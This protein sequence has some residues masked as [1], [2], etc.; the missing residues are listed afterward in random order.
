MGKG[1]QRERERK[2]ARSKST[3]FINPKVIHYQWRYF[4]HAN[5]FS[6]SAVH[7]RPICT[8]SW[9]RTFFDFE[10]S[11][12][13][14][15]FSFL[16]SN[17]LSLSLSLWLRTCWSACD[18]SAITSGKV[19]HSSGSDQTLCRPLSRRFECIPVR[20]SIEPRRVCIDL[21][22]WRLRRKSNFRRKLNSKE[23]LKKLLRKFKE[24]QTLNFKFKVPL[25][26]QTSS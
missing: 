5:H 17:S 26:Y 4:R 18:Q 12:T 10:L 20:S 7:Q 13:S 16:T 6:I 8:H 25:K 9:L 11:S 24:S 15:F 1:I 21:I 2:M 14:N 23:T 19:L 22:A 3:L